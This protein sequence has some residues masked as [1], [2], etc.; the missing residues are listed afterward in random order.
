MRIVDTMQTVR[1]YQKG[2]LKFR[3]KKTE[4]KKKENER[5]RKEATCS[6]AEKQNE[7]SLE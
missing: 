4:E 2:P 6:L 5:K 7:I 3:E 1:E